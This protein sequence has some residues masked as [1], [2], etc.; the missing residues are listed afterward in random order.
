MT[1][2]YWSWSVCRLHD[3]TTVSFMGSGYSLCVSQLR[4][5]LWV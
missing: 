3:N 4:S 5:C 1:A 2:N